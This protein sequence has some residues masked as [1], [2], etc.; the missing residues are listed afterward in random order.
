MR[1]WCIDTLNLASPAGLLRSYVW[2]I[3]GLSTLIAYA[4]TWTFGST[5]T[6]DLPKLLWRADSSNHKRLSHAKD[7]GGSDYSAEGSR[8]RRRRR[9]GD[10][11]RHPGAGVTMDEMEVS[12]CGVESEEDMGEESISGQRMITMVDEHGISYKVPH[13]TPSE[14]ARCVDEECDEAVVE[15]REWMCAQQ[16]EIS[17]HEKTQRYLDSMRK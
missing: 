8:K 5:A 13:Y 10:S 17:S 12:G 14:L 3:N 7:S 1:H 11:Q 16:G 4:K 15:A 6:R 2:L 9:T